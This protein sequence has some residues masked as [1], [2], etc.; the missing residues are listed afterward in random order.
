[1]SDVKSEIIEDIKKRFKVKGGQLVW[2]NSTA[3]Y[4][5]DDPVK[6]PLIRVLKDR[7]MLTADVVAFLERGA[8]FQV[9]RPVEDAEFRA[10]LKKVR[11]AVRDKG[12]E[13]FKA[14]AA[15]DANSMDIKEIL[16]VSRSARDRVCEVDLKVD[17]LSQQVADLTSLVKQL[18]ADRTKS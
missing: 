7:P 4:K 17:A 18:L 9:N 5:Q 10:M 2:S 3:F 14:S 8:D 15:S 12:R 6:A 13:A 11:Q 1:M 16:A